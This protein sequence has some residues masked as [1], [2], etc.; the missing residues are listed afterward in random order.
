MQTENMVYLQLCSPNGL[1]IPAKTHPDV[2]VQ[3]VAARDQVKA[4]KY[5]QDHGIPDVKGSYQG[6]VVPLRPR[7][8]RESHWWL[9]ALRLQYLGIVS[10]GVVTRWTHLITPE[11]SQERL[12][13]S[14]PSHDRRHERMTSTA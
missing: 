6:K 7:C 2:V 10:H 13:L 11:S 4:K 9:K 1:F 12:I 5:A 14:S 3:S 8:Q